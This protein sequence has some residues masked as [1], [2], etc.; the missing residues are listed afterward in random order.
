MAETNRDNRYRNVI[1][2]K[3]KTK[4]EAFAKSRSKRF[5]NRREKAILSK[6]SK[7]RVRFKIFL[8]YLRGIV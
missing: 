2:D 6:K 5:K 3:E 8:V 7:E 1:A 4:E